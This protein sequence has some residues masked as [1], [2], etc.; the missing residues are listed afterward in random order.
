MQLNPLLSASALSQAY[1]R[2][3]RIQ[4][5]ELVAR[6]D[7]SRMRE[8]LRQTPW[9][10]TFNE[11]HFVHRLSSEEQA[12]LPRQRVGE[13][14]AA[15]SQRAA[16]EFQFLYEY[17]PIF[18]RYFALNHPWMPIFEA[19]EFLNSPIMLNFLRTV[20]GISDIRWADA[21]ATSYSAGHFLK[22]H[23]DAKI[24][25]KRLAAY[26]LNLTPDWSPDWGG[27]L[28]FLN[29]D[30]DVEHGYRP[31]MNALNLFTVPSPHNV[32]MV[33]MFASERRLS[34]TGWLRGDTPP[35]AF[36]RYPQSSR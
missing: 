2:A 26:V 15:I 13:M 25:E 35:G 22:T 27:F 29:S 7:A 36:N 19:Y 23:D 24:E 31:Q 6:A 1:A 28:Q 12:Q 21:Q 9:S 30:G 33:A 10:I 16:G 8:A 14:M 32:G 4:I 5:R 17:D 18:V 11:G 3:G 20:T 34:I